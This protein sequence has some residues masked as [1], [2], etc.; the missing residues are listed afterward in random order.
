M[1]LLLTLTACNVHLAADRG[2]WSAVERLSPGQP[3]EVRLEKGG[4]DRGV[5]EK[6]TRESLRLASGVSFAQPEVKRIIDRSRSRRGRNALIG[7][8]VGVPAALAMEKTL[9]EYLRNETTHTG[10]YWQMWAIPIGIGAGIGAAFPSYPT[11]YRK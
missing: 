5:V 9:G 11:I 10:I 2:D 7:A 3:I 8:A 6:A 1:K 4:V